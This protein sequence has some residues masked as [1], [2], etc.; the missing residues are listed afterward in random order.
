VDEVCKKSDRPRRY[1]LIRRQHLQA[2][3]LGRQQQV[4]KEHHLGNCVEKIRAQVLDA[5]GRL[6]TLLNAGELRLL[7]HRLALLRAPLEL[8]AGPEQPVPV[9]IGF[10]PTRA[11]DLQQ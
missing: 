5:I 3:F 1:Q 9:L 2:S 11:L 8:A 7:F 6:Q 10:P 4:D